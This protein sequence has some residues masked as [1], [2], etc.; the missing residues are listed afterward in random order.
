VSEVEEDDH[1]VPQLYTQHT[2]P[3]LVVPTQASIIEVG[4]RCLLS[5]RRAFHDGCHLTTKRL[6]DRPIVSIV[7]VHGRQYSAEAS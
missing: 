6:S 7:V 4:P 2:Q 5:D 3:S 1:S